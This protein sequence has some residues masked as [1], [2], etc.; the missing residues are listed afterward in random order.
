MNTVNFPTYV[1]SSKARAWIEEM[2]A[3][4]KPDHVHWCDGS[5]AEYDNLCELAC[6]QRHFYQTQ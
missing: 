5:Q 6:Q 4:C 2:V 1:K 3:L